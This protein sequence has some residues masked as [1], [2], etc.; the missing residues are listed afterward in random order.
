MERIKELRRKQEV[1][2]E[3]E[4]A[5]SFEEFQKFTI[6]VNEN[7][8]GGPIGRHYGHYLVLSQEEEVLRVIYRVIDLALKIAL[9]LKDGK[10]FTIYY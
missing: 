6:K 7:K 2:G 10:Q 3:V 9:C 8:E 5:A 4:L 1:I